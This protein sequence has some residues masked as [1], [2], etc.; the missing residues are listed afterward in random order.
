MAEIDINDELKMLNMFV[1]PRPRMTIDRAI[2]EIDALREALKKAIF[3]KT[4][5]K[6]TL[7]EY[8]P[9]GSDYEYDWLPEVYEWGKLA[10]V[11]MSKH[12]PDFYY[13]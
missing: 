6:K 3:Q 9:A 1:D 11:D 7:V 10:G 4:R 5:V 12:T 2:L 8:D 13:L